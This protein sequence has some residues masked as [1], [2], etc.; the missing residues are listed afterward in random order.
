MLFLN[1]KR[2]N[3]KA[4]VSPVL[5][6]WKRFQITLGH[7]F[8]QKKARPSRDSFRI[9]K[10]EGFMFREGQYFLHH[11]LQEGRVNNLRKCYGNK[12]C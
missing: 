12:D 6:L 3:F 4:S 7:E 1:T 5:G 2:M 8:I 10:L 11:C 9:L